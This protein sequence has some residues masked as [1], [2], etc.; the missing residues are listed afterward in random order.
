MDTARYIEEEEMASAKSEEEKEK[1]WK[2]Y[3]ENMSKVIENVMMKYTSRYKVDAILYRDELLSRLN[4]KKQATS[5]Y[6]STRPM[7]VD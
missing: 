7:H 5:F 4:Q 6:T 3:S 1:I 2:N